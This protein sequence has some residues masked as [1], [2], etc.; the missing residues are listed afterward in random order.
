[1]AQTSTP[2]LTADRGTYADVRQY[3]EELDRR[4]LLIKV[5]RLTNKDTEIMP[6]VRLMRS[7]G[8]IGAVAPSRPGRSRDRPD[9]G[10]R[11]PPG[12]DPEQPGRCSP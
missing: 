6:I 5:D 10:R 4:G 11:R 12:S 9:R 2:P 3:L 7:R 1:M 8:S